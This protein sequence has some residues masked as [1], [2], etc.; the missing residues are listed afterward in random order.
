MQRWTRKIAPVDTL[1]APLCLGALLL[2]VLRVLDRGKARPSRTREVSE[3]FFFFVLDQRRSRGCAA[4]LGD[5]D[6]PQAN[7]ERI[8]AGAS[9]V[10]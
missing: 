6:R 5:L 10:H 4:A 3:Y 8:T 2:G 9:V 7:I 1:T